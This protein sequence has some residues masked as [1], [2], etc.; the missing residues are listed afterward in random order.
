MTTNRNKLGVISMSLRASGVDRTY[1]RA[2]DAA[3][4]AGLTVVVA[5]GNSKSAACGFSSAFAE[6]ANHRWCHEL[7]RRA[8]VLQ[9]LPVS[10]RKM[11]IVNTIVSFEWRRVW[12]LA[13]PVTFQHIRKAS[14][15]TGVVR[16]F[17]RQAVPSLQLVFET[18][19]DLPLSLA[20]RWLVPTSLEVLRSCWA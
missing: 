13:S 6:Q 7:Q 16:R 18:T 9:Q 4:E 2:I 17:G 19:L 10:G 11:T 8:R 15:T 5:A 1:D 3:A 12:L 20:R 14:A